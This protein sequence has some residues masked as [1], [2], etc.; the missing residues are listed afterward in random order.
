MKHSQQP[1]GMDQNYAAPRKS[2]AVTSASASLLPTLDMLS[3][4]GN[5]HKLFIFM[6]SISKS[7]KA[8]CVKENSCIQ[9]GISPFR[10]NV[11]FLERILYKTVSENDA[12]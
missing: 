4:T 10:G 12:H 3:K 7:Q 8:C 6:D 11:H 5:S 9:K 2:R 1:T